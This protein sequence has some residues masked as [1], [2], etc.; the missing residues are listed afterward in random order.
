MVTQAGFTDKQEAVR[1][2]PLLRREK[3]YPSS[4]MARDLDVSP[5]TPATS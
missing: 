3:C 5:E 2:S 1:R 4:K